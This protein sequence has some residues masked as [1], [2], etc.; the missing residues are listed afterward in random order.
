M[1]PR[2]AKSLA[3]TQA[4]RAQCAEIFLP[5]FDHCIT[6]ALSSY[7][8]G[9]PQRAGIELRHARETAASLVC[10]CGRPAIRGTTLCAN[11]NPTCWRVYDNGGETLDRYTVCLEVSRWVDGKPLY[12]C[13]GCSEG[14]RACSQ[15]SEAHEGRHLGKRVKLEALDAD[16]RRHIMTRLSP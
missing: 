14:G 13:L 5:L 2:F 4:M 15:F 6:L 10:S 1:T 8:H 11:H 9:Y 3:S 16:T 7:E 12:N